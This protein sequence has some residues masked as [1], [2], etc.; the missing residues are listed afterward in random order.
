MKDS[1]GRPST[2]DELSLC[3]RISEGDCQSSWRD[4]TSCQV[5]LPQ[6]SGLMIRVYGGSD[7]AQVLFQSIVDR[8]TNTVG[9]TG[10][11]PWNPSTQLPTVFSIV[12]AVGQT[13]FTMAE[14]LAH[15]SFRLECCVFR[16]PTR[17]HGSLP[18]NRVRISGASRISG[19]TFATE[20]EEL[21]LIS[22][23]VS[24]IKLLTKNFAL[25]GP[26]MARLL[27]SIYRRLAIV[28]PVTLLGRCF[29]KIRDY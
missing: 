8:P 5:S 6:R 25:W 1:V 28:S 15:E 3:L 20:R 29:G 17:S 2:R 26:G 12:I 23:F 4:L 19:T 18:R 21:G 7:T 22:L 16:R 14:I 27:P 11:I 24:T 13:E 10:Q 9:L